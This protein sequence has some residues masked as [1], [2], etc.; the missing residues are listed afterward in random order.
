MGRGNKSSPCSLSLSLSL[1]LFLSFSQSKSQSLFFYSHCFIYHQLFIYYSFTFP[2]LGFTRENQSKKVL[3]LF[4]QSVSNHHRRIFSFLYL[5]ASLFYK[6]Q[7]YLCANKRQHLC[8]TNAPS[9]SPHFKLSGSLCILF[10]ISQETISVM[11]WWEKRGREGFLLFCGSDFFIFHRNYF[12]YNAEMNC[13][14]WGF[15]FYPRIFFKSYHILG[16]DSC[17]YPQMY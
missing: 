6:R 17:R 2:A 15:C 4:V 3:H 11:G 16:F 13:N 1:S 7:V 12:A 5:K 9:L 10:T 8:R 14:F